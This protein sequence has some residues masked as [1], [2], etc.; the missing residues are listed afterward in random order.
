MYNAMIHPI[1]NLPIKGALWYQG[2]SNGAEGESYYQKM[3]ALI[4]GWRKQWAQ[5]DFPFY[6]VQLASFQAVTDDAAGGNGWAQ[7]REAQRKALQIPNTGMAVITDTVPLPER[8]DIHPRNKFDVGLRLA[9]WALGRD[10]GLKDTV[11]SGPLLKGIESAGGKVRVKFEHTGGGLMAGRKDGLAVAA[12]D[13]GAKLNGFAVAGADRKWVWA[14]AVID[15]DTVVVSAGEVKE[16]VA[17]RYAYRM[18]PGGAN[19]YNRAGLPASPFRS[20]DW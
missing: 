5:G 17:V 1:V 19:L 3:E 18:N 2:E 6:F 20:D 15:G 9:Q 8:D 14:D 16:P 13:A 4:G 12:E 7:L 10:Y 11:V